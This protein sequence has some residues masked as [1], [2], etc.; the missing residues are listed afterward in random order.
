M[1]ESFKIPAEFGWRCGT[2]IKMTNIIHTSENSFDSTLA[3]GRVYE[4]HKKIVGPYDNYVCDHCSR[5][6][7]FASDVIPYPCPTV[8]ALEG[9]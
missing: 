4:L 3:V 1:S 9:N 6:T 8:K 7:V 2:E 5:L